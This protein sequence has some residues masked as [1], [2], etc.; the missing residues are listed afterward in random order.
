M[1][2]QFYQETSFSPE[3]KRSQTMETLSLIL[4]IIAILTSCC[5]YLSIVSGALSIMFALLS[6]GGERTL[7]RRALIGLILGSL[8]LCVTFVFFGFSFYLLVQQ[9]GGWENMLDMFQTMTTFGSY[10]EMLQYYFDTIGTI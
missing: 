4:G 10:E 8:G 7:S 2:Q 1:D 5:I 9:C 3:S 6:R